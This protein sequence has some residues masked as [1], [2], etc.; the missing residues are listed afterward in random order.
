MFYNLKFGA[1]ITKIFSSGAI[2]V[3]DNL[4]QR[5]TMQLARQLSSAGWE[6]FRFSNEYLCYVVYLLLYYFTI[7]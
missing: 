7:Y 4:P 5:M 1:S 2:D 3:E 6:L